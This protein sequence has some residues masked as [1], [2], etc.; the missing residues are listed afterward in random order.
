MPRKPRPGLNPE[1]AAARGGWGGKRGAPVQE[2]RDKR[3]WGEVEL[4]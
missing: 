2:E 1:A 3:G 4:A